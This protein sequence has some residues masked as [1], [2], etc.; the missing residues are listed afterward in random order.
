MNFNEQV[1]MV[2]DFIEESHEILDELDGL[3]L[4]FEQSLDETLDPSVINDVL[5]L[6]HTFKGN[7]GM[8]GFSCMQSYIH[9]LEDIFKSLQSERLCFDRELVDFIIH[10]AGNVRHSISQIIPDMP[11][12]D[13]LQDE[14]DEIE[15]FLEEKKGSPQQ[16]NLVV[17]LSPQ[18]K[19]AN[20][21]GKKSNLLKVE[22]ERMEQLL[23]LMG[24]LVIHR[25][26][27][28]QI[29]S[30][31]R[32][33][34]GEK[35]IVLDLSNTSEQIG[36]ITTELHE[37]IMKVRMLP[38]KQVFMRFPRYVRDLARGMGKEI[39][40]SFEGEETELDKKVIDE[41]GE[42]L[43]HL[44]RNS[45][46]HGIEPP[47]ERVV[48]GKPK[49][50]NI[51]LKASHE[52]SHIIITVKDDGKG[53]DR[54]KL[55]AKAKKAGLTVKDDAESNEVFNLIFVSGLSTSDSITEI[56]GRGV[57]MDVVKKSLTRING[58]IEVESEVNKG[59]C[60]TIKLPLTLAIISALM[61]E[62][63]GEQYAIP[64]TSVIESIRVR[65]DEIHMVNNCEVTN[66]RGK[67]F[68]LIRLSSLFGLESLNN[69]TSHYVVIVQS[70][71][72]E[73]GIVVDSLLGQ[74]EIVIKALDD[75]IGNSVGIAGAT[76]LGDGRVVLIVDVLEL[77]N[78]V[79]HQGEH[80]K[81][82]EAQYA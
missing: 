71:M 21:F 29:D 78:E 50:G 17:N 54:E 18:K 33:T 32:E 55:I 26:H 2:K 64:L 47:E 1:E 39:N 31:F 24:E 14:L 22:F 61:V 20:P 7:S 5:G 76:I 80:E 11:K 12:M 51:T 52:S 48:L 68:P 45:I 63:S 67:I 13:L 56:S 77:M 44:I 46:D 30:Q 72:G 10:C 36:K 53:I 38:I 19:T 73:M 41:I 74:Q 81:K 34:F 3:L 15:G 62:V 60:F 6:L 40:I 49:T 9:K 58:A 8:M 82:R 79:R 75:Y 23:N 37:T 35:G 4:Q 25:T 57:G 70:T 28:D 69:E 66:I 27:L 59:T 43:M 16:E 42:P 65:D